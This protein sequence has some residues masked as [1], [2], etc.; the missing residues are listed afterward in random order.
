MLP[1]D[2]R[3]EIE[4]VASVVEQLLS[5]FVFIVRGVLGLRRLQLDFEYALVFLNVEDLA[6]RLVVIRRESESESDLSEYWEALPDRPEW[7]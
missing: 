4:C 6:E 2:V 1:R 5:V 3:V 7:S